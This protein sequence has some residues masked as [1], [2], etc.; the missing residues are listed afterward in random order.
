MSKNIGIIAKVV[1]LQ[2]PSYFDQR[3]QPKGGCCNI[4]GFRSSPMAYREGGQRGK[5][6]PGG[7]LR[8]AAKKGN[9]KKKKKKKKKR[10]E[11]KIKK[12]KETMGEAY[13]LSKLIKWSISAAAPLCTYNLPFWRPHPFWSGRVIRLI[14]RAFANGA[15]LYRGPIHSGVPSRLNHVLTLITVPTILAPLFILAP[16]LSKSSMLGHFA[17]CVRRQAPVSLA[18]APRENFTERHYYYEAAGCMPAVGAKRIENCVN[19]FRKWVQFTLNC[20]N[21]LLKALWRLGLR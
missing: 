9:K 16:Q 5:F 6:A 8:G 19:V 10:I 15:K 4:C 13:N 21:L 18:A 1:T 3:L 12:E 14:I 20:L 7:T 2:Q 17:P 11:E